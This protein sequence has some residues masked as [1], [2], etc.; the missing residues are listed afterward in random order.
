MDR[1][2]QLVRWF[3]RVSPLNQLKPSLAKR[4]GRRLARAEGLQIYD[5]IQGS[6][7]MRL[8]LGVNYERQIYLHARDIVLLDVVRRILRPGDVY[9]DVGANLGVLVLAAAKRI[10]PGGRIFA[11]EP[12]PQVCERLEENLELND[13][14]G[15][16]L[17]RKACSHERSTA[18]LYNFEDKSHDTASIGRREDDSV[19]DS[20][21]IETIPID[22][23]VAE[24]PRLVKIDVEGAEWLALR[25]AERT[26]FDGEPPHLIVE[27]NPR[28][29]ESFGYHPTQVLDWIMERNPRY[30]LH[31]IHS[32]RLQRASAEQVARYLEKHPKTIDLWFDPE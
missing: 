13:V 32:K 17:I 19:A 23:V 16:T 25:G 11:F 6:F 18:T 26:L 29:S 2:V 24:R 14:T 31:M 12:S 15:V 5:G 21:T 7:R 27:L 3:N 8:D 10:S 22:D 9:V 1:I 28:A 4:V 20:V 30:R